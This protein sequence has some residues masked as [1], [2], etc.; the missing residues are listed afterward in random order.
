MSTCMGD[1]EMWLFS[2]ENCYL[3]WYLGFVTK[4]KGEQVLSS[5]LG[6]KH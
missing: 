4:E 2:Y 6:P 3:E 1:W 5:S